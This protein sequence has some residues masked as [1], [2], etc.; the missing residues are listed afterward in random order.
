MKTRIILSAAFA[1]I[2]TLLI[3][4]A[5]KKDKVKGCMDPDSMNYNSSATEDDGSCKYQ[6]SIVFWNN[7]ALED[8]LTAHGADTLIYYID[9]VKVGTSLVAG[10]GRSSA[11]SCGQSGVYTLTEQLGNVK[12]KTYTLNVN[13]QTGHFQW[14]TT[15]T[16]TAK[17]SCTPFQLLYSAI[18]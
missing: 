6:G 5:C 3:I 9:N 2:V 16:V 13:D 12:S 11:P 17:P 1:I 8:T 10:S 18:Q 4:S 14:S 7:V 15:V